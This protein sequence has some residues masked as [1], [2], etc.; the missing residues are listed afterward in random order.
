MPNPKKLHP[1]KV[2]V[3]WPVRLFGFKFID[4]LFFSLMVPDIIIDGFVTQNSE[5]VAKRSKII[6]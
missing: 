4:M 3:G 1:I 5:T 6:G 2:A